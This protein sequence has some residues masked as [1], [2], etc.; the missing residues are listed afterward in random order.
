M[1]LLLW[2]PQKKEEFNF[3]SLNA[4]TREQDLLRRHFFFTFLKKIIKILIRKQIHS[5]SHKMENTIPD[6]LI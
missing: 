1:C 5:S 2:N 3:Q 6:Q 4:D